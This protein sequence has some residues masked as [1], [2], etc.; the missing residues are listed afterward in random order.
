M[1]AAAA[2]GLSDWFSKLKSQIREELFKL[3][4]HVKHFYHFLLKI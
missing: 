3:K 1:W 2:A 4:N